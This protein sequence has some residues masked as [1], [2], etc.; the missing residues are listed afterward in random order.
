MLPLV[1][2][3]KK[4]KIKKS[5]FVGWINKDHILDQ[6]SAVVEVSSKFPRRVMAAAAFQSPMPLLG[7]SQ[8]ES[9]TGNSIS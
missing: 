5:N 4:K 2:G 1:P 9:R 7:S 8:Q 6:E 3:L